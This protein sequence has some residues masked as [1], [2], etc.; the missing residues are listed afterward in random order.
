V[1]NNGTR[2]GFKEAVCIT[3]ILRLHAPFA[4]LQ[5]YIQKNTPPHPHIWGEGGQLNKDYHDGRLLRIIKSTT[6]PYQEE[7]E[8]YTSKVKKI[9]SIKRLSRRKIYK[10]RAGI[11]FLGFL[12]YI[13]L[14][15]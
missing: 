14:K 6:G 8:R 3:P 9:T 1:R 4:R 13:Y 15:T 7:R 5:K 10:G 11:G 12:S 2:K